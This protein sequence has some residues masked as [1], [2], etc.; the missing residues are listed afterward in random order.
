MPIEIKAGERLVFGL[1]L[2]PMR[3]IFPIF[4]FVL[5]AFPALAAG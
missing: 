4:L 2:T 5:M 3:R 1:W